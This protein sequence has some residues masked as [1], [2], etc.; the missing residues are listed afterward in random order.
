M[1]T[2][3]EMFGTIKVIKMLTLALTNSLGNYK[4]YYLNQ[5]DDDGRTFVQNFRDELAT[6]QEEIILR[7]KTVEESN[8]E[9]QVKEY[10]YEW[11]LPDRVLNSISS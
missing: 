5:M 11:L 2:G 9:N 8:T 7:N 3:K 10:P 4:W 1:P 6:I